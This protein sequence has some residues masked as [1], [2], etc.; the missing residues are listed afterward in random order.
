[1]AEK[2]GRTEGRLGGS[3]GTSD[4]SEGEILSTK[5][6]TRQSASLRASVYPGDPCASQEMAPDKS[7]Q[8][9][10]QSQECAPGREVSRRPFCI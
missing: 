4:Q 8:K 10:S 2:R 5:H 7:N 1:M 3:V 6:P 9:E